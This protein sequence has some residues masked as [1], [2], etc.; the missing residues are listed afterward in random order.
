MKHLYFFKKKLPGG[1]TLNSQ[2]SHLIF[3]AKLWKFT[4][5]TPEDVITCTAVVLTDA[6][7]SKDYP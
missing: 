5:I 7:V 1:F 4:V 6:G 2:L 3:V